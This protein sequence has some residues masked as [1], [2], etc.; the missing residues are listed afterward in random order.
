MSRSESIGSLYAG[1]H[2][3]NEQLVE[4]VKRATPEQLALRA[5][6]H[7]WPAWA[8][9]SHL[10]GARIYWLC[11]VVGEPL[12]GDTPFVE[13]TGEGWED[14][15][16]HVRR[17]DELEEALRSSW[18]IVD[19]C[20]ARWTREMLDDEVVRTRSDG[21]AQLHTRQ[22]ILF[23]LITHDAFHGGEVSQVLGAHGFEGLDPWARMHRPG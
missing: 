2:L 19:A 4:L 10:A 15:L 18:R 16:D 9:L 12:P 3:V 8:I 11:S 20:L 1:W 6:Q 14:H 5:S 13:P 17:P 22:S 7:Q 21:I 23:R